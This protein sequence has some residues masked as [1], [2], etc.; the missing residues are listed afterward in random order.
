MLNGIVPLFKEK[1]MTSFDCIRKMRGILK[2]KKIGHS[3]TLD[4]NVDGVLPI[5]I[6]N[7]TK[8]VDYL[9]SS[10]KVYRGSIT[11]GFSTTT[12]DLDGD[13]VDRKSLK[14]KLSNEKINELLNS[15]VSDDLIQIPPMYSAIKVNGRRLYEYARN[16]EKVERPEHHV[17]I[18]YFKQIKDSFYDSKKHE[19]TIYFEVGCGKGTY[20]RTLAVDFGKKIGMPAVMSNLTRIKSGNF[21]IDQTFKLSDVEDA[22]HKDNID[23][24]M[25]SID[26]ALLQY[27]HVEMSDSQWKLVQNGVWLRPD[28]LDINDEKCVLTYKKDIK[29]LYYFSKDKQAFKPEKM[30]SNK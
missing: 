27:K 23:S 21:T 18:N 30:F 20:V 26:H 13:V 5:C 6:G 1:G 17:Q 7:G 9:M 19:Q 11:L 16:N 10:G 12:E 24:V 29:A 3:G 8:V 4:P 14:K 2:M 15:F 25:Y 28:E 22:M